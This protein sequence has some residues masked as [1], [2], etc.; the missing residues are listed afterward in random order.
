VDTIAIAEAIRKELLDIA[1]WL[2]SDV[3]D[4]IIAGIEID[5]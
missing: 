5:V 2:F 4:K 3:D 1:F